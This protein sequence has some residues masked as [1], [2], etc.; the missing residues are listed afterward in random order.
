MSAKKIGEAKIDMEDEL[1]TVANGKGK[2]AMSR[3][4]VDS[5][6]EI[7]EARA[8]YSKTASKR[9]PSRRQTEKR[10][11][12]YEERDELKRRLRELLVVAYEEIRQESFTT[13]FVLQKDHDFDH[14]GQWR[15]CLYKGIVYQFDRP[16]YSDEAM[17]QQIHELDRPA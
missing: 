9:T 17:L 2:F 7:K 5:R 10:D 8:K 1:W 12:Y 6:K 11:E 3:R 14:H 16:G 15:Y 4:H 13:P